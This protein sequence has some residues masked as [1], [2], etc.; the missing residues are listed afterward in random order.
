[1][2]PADLSTGRLDPLIRAEPVTADYLIVLASQESRGDFAATVLGDGKDCAQGGHRGPQPS[3]LAI[4][5]PRRLVDIN[6]L[7]L[8]DRSRE[9]VVRGFQGDGRLPFQLGD[10]PGGDRK[11]K[12]VAYQLLDLSLAEAIGPSE[13][14]QHG[15]E[16]RAEGPS[17]DARWQG[18]TGRLTAARTGQAME[19]KLVDDR[20]DPGQFSDLMDQR[21]RVV[22]GETMA[23]SA[24]SGW[25]TI[26]RLVN[27]FGRDQ[28]AVGFAM[29]KLPAPVLTARGSRGLA[30]HSNRIRGRGLRRVG[31]VELEPVLEIVDAS[32]KFGKTLFVE[33]DEP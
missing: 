16:V 9:F 20:L 2:R 7:G 14:G 33:L 12:Q 25:L 6:H 31:G 4:L 23:A 8:M 26:D 19:P 32:F 29:S 21:F 27:L 1:M 13:C 24:A 22:A 15:L 11:G 18:A 17:G 28:R 3:L 30:L 10:H 5:A